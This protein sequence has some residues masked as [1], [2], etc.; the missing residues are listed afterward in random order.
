[1]SI[2]FI[3]KYKLHS[4]RCARKKGFIES[5]VI[6]ALELFVVVVVSFHISRSVA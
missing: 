6:L 4:Q 1:M 2:P 5:L 3:K